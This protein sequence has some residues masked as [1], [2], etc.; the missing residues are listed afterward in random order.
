[1]S[2]RLTAISVTAWLGAS[3]ATQAL[4]P[5]RVEP[6]IAPLPPLATHAKRGTLQQTLLDTR[7][8]LGQ[9]RQ[10]Q[11]AARACVTLEIGR[12]SCRERV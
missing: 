6:E 7:D 12:A 5:T 8:A 3:I 1:M 11:A 4:G 10:E 9:W 2:A